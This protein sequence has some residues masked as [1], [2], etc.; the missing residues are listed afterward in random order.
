MIGAIELGRPPSDLGF[1]LAQIARY[2]SDENESRFEL[3]ECFF[4]GDTSDRVGAKIDHLR[5]PE[6]DPTPGLSQILIVTHSFLAE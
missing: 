2:V 3:T 6:Y 5:R 1:L 4:G